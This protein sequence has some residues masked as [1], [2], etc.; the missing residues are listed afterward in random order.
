[1]TPEEKLKLIET[2]L[3]QAEKHCEEM[4]LSHAVAQAQVDCLKKQ[5]RDLTP[6]P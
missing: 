6:K 1:M 5:H 4:R 2:A 3:K